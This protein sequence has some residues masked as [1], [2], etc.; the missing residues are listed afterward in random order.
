MSTFVEVPAAT[1]DAFLVAK[2]FSPSIQGLE[3]YLVARATGTLRHPTAYGVY[4]R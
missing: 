3:K 1:L 4:G 2:K